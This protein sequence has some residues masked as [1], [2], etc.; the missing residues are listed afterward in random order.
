LNCERRTNTGHYRI[1]ASW[2]RC[3]T[4]H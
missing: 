2:L 4:G 1:V 3:S